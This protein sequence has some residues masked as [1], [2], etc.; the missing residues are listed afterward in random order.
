MTVSTF[1]QPTPQF[2][3]RHWFSWYDYESDVNEEEYANDLLL[4]CGCYGVDREDVELLLE[5]WN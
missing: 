4:I 1:E 3:Y 2:D 5:F